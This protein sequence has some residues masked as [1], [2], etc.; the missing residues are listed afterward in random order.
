MTEQQTPVL[1]PKDVPY[2]RPVS[3]APPEKTER[4]TLKGDHYLG[5]LL[6]HSWPGGGYLLWRF[7]LQPLQWSRARFICP[8]P[9]SVP[10]RCG[11]RGRRQCQSQGIPPPSTL[12]GGGTVQ[13]VFVNPGDVVTAGQPLYTIY[14]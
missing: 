8:P 5:I 12:T 6:G 9:P 10:S 7:V 2:I 1:T 13:E 3:T 14:G 4:N 11:Y